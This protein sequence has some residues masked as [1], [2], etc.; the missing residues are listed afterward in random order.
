LYAYRSTTTVE[1]R[2]I[3]PELRCGNEPKRSS[4]FNPEQSFVD[5][6]VLAELT[7]DIKAIGS[8][9]LLVICVGRQANAL[10]VSTT[11]IHPLNLPITIAVYEGQYVYVFRRD[12]VRFACFKSR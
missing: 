12:M 3:L 4:F 5:L 2:Q 1:G 10:G 7:E 11:D 6:S 8:L 9:S